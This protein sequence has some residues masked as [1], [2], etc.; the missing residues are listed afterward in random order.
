MRFGRRNIQNKVYYCFRRLTSVRNSAEYKDWSYF[1]NR[2]LEVS[3]GDIISFNLSG[4]SQNENDL[5]S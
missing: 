3:E 5:R 4:I 2:L 1:I